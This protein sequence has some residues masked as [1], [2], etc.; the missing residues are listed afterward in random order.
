ML[1]GFS[2]SYLISRVNR[3]FL[4]LPRGIMESAIVITEAHLFDRPFFDCEY[5]KRT[6]IA[7]FNVN[8]ENLVEMYDLSFY[9]FDSVDGYGDGE[10]FDGVS[11][12]L[13]TS[14]IFAIKYSNS[15]TFTIESNG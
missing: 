1:C 13:R 9:F 6:T 12:G 5:L 8:L 7:Y 2:Y 4:L 3:T 15:M 14:L 11:I 10:H